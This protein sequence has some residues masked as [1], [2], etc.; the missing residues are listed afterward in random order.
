M[1]TCKHFAARTLIWFAA[2]A[3]SVQG[4][5]AKSCGCVDSTACCQKGAESRRCCCSPAKTHQGCC[6]AGRQAAATHAC[7][8]DQTKRTSACKCGFG[9]QCGK[10]KE[11]QPTA[12]PIEGNCSTDKVVGD[13]AAAFITDVVQQKVQQQH[14]DVS[15]ELGTITALDRCVSLC[16]FTL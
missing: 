12:P 16:R 5:P 10:T 3:V 13:A 8:G 4:L 15:I 2:V 11:P 6:S 1:W 14:V 9:C 7:C